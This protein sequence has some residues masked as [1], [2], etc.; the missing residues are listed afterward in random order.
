[1]TGTTEPA[2]PPHTPRPPRRLG[3]LVFVGA[4]LIVVGVVLAVALGVLGTGGSSAPK[5]PAISG[6]DVTLD[7]PG[8]YAIY[9]QGGSSGAQAPAAQVVGPDL[10]VVP[11]RDAAPDSS[12]GPS[13][14]LV[15]EFTATGAGRYR[16]QAGGAASATGDFQVTEAD[17]ATG[18]QRTLGAGIGVLVAVLGLVLLIVGLR[19]RR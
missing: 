1:M 2:A 11:V 6:G 19:R 18:E 10:N 7:G 12:S 13:G 17:S 9:Y 14:R 5:V 8:D 3:P 4:A 16:V 15:G